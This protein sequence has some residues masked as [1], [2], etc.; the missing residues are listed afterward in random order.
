MVRTALLKLGTTLEDILDKAARRTS[1]FHR[2]ALLLWRRWWWGLL[3]LLLLIS[4]GLLSLRSGLQCPREFLVAGTVGRIKLNGSGHLI[5]SLRLR[6]GNSVH[7]VGRS[8]ADF[9]I[10]HRGASIEWVELLQLG[11][12]LGM[13]IL[14]LLLTGKN[15]A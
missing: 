3:L 1:R 11:L 9:G 12:T 8:L 14:L 5:V 10:R 4:K 13:M 7:K 15:I 6:S 2:G